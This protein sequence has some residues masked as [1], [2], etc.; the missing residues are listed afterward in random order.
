MA[1]KRQRGAGGKFVSSGGSVTGGTGDIKPQIMTVVVGSAG[2][3]DDYS[4]IQ[5]NVPRIVLNPTGGSTIMELLK[6]WWYV[7]LDDLG[8]IDG[9]WAAYLSTTRIRIVGETFNAGTLQN[10][11]ERPGVFA[12]VALDKT[13]VTTGGHSIVFPLVVD[14]T[15]GNGNGILVATP[16]IFAT[17]G[18]L[19]NT[20]TTSTATAKI[21]Y[22]LVN[23]DLTE[24]VGIVASQS[25]AN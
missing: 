10:D 24:Y 9:I 8:D 7:A 23:V 12:M 19:G 2:A 17:F 13:L 22:R 4:F 20:A 5:V 11:A 25:T 6:V 1:S 21:L 18:A 16:T 3:V 14:L 15:D